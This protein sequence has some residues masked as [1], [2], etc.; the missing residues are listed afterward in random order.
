[1]AEGVEFSDGT[2]ALRWLDSGVSETNRE[3]GVRPT[4]VVHESIASVTA[5]H[6]HGGATYVQYLDNPPEADVP[7]PRDCPHAAPFRYCP[8][9]VADPCPIGLGGKS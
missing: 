9:C 5:L 6:G 1:M 7:Q 4:T 2:V 3:R 8:G